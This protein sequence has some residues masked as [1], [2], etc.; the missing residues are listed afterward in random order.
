M[1]ISKS[2]RWLSGLLAVLMLMTTMLSN[3]VFAA[4]NV[5]VDYRILHVDCGRK[6]FSAES[7]KQAIDIAAEAGY[8]DVELAIGNDG[9]RFLLNDMSVT[10][11]DKTYKSDEVKAAIQAGNQDYY[12]EPNGINELTQTEMDD[13]IQYAVKKNIGIIPLLNSPGHMDAILAAMVDLGIQNAAYNGS[14]RTVDV[15]NA[16]AVAF[17]QALVGK[18]ID[19]FAGEGCKEFN[20]GADEYANDIS[21]MG[22]THLQKTGKY[23]KFVEYVNK[24]CALVEHAGMT[25]MA[26]NDGIYYNSNTTDRFDENLMVCYWS[27]G[28]AGYEVASASFIANQGHKMINTHGDYYY[29]LQDGDK[30]QRPSNPE[31]FNNQVFMDRNGNGMIEDPAGAM[32]CI[33]SDNPRCNGWDGSAVISDAAESIREVG[34]AMQVNNPVEPETKP[35][36]V[37]SAPMTVGG[38]QTV[39]LGE[40]AEWKSSAANVVE[41]KA[42]DDGKSATLTAKSAGTATITATTENVIYTA[43]VTVEN[44]AVPGEKITL[45]VGSSET[46]TVNGHVGTEGTYQ[47][48]DGIAAYTISHK[49][50]SA[51]TTD[52]EQVTD[53]QNGTY[54]IGDGNNWLTIENNQLN[55]TN[56]S[57]KATRWTITES[58]DGYIIRSQADGKYL[59]TGTS[60][61][62]HYLKLDSSPKEWNWDNNGGFK[63]NH[64][65]IW[66]TTYYLRYS[67]SGWIVTDNNNEGTLGTAYTLPEEIPGGPYTEITFTGKQVG[68]TTVTIDDKVYNIQVVEEDLSK[69][70]PLSIEYWITNATTTDADGQESFKIQANAAYGEAG[71]DLSVLPQTTQK[72]NRDVYYWRSRLL[73]KEKYNS[74]TSGTEEQTGNAG[75]DETTSGVGFTKVRYYAGAWQVFTENSEWVTVEQNH[76]LVAYYL[77]HIKVTDEVES[78][79]ADWGKKGDGSK[80]D[81]DYLDPSMVC[82]VSVQVVYEDNTTNPSGTDANSLASKTMCYGY[83]ETHRGIGTI[84]LQETSNYEIYKV[85]AETGE[86]RGSG[87]TWGPYQ[88][89]SFNWDKNPETVWEGTSNGQVILHNDANK[90]SSAGSNKNLMWDENYEAILLKV[91]VRAKKT[92]DSLT[93]HYMDK[94]AG[95]KEF[96]NYNI[97]VSG[98][99]TFDEGFALK[100]G[101]LVNNSVTN[102]YGQ[103]QTVSTDLKTLPQLSA[104][105]LYSNFT[106]VDAKRS[107]NGKE[108]WL[109][110]TFNNTKEYVID[111][112]L[113]V[114]ID[115]KDIVEVTEA[116]QFEVV[117][118]SQYGTAQVVGDKLQYTPNQALAGVDTVM[119]KVSNNTGEPATWNIYIYPASNVLYEDSFFAQDV[120]NKYTAWTEGTPDSAVQS[121]DNTTYGWDSAYATS[122]RENSMNSAWSVDLTQGQTTC[123]LTTTFT[124][125][126][127]DLIGTCGP[128]TGYVYLTLKNNTTG[129]GKVVVVD[130]SFN[131]TEYGTLHQVPLAHVELDEGTYTAT[132]FGSYRAAAAA[133]AAYSLAP[134]ANDTQEMLERAYALA[135]EV[136]SVEMIYFDDNSML[137]G[138]NG[139]SKAAYALSMDDAQP[140]SRAAGQP[141]GKIEIDGFRVYRPSDVDAYIGTEKNV[142]YTNILDAVSGEFG[143]YIEANANGEYTAKDYESK[144]GPQNEI[145]LAENQSIA[146]KFSELQA[147]NFSVRAVNKDSVSYTVQIG[148]DGKK[149]LFTASRTEMYQLVENAGDDAVV[150]IKNTTEGALLA[151]G[152]LKTG[153]MATLATMDEAALQTAYAMLSAPAQPEPE[154]FV[155]EKLDLKVSA[156]N[157]LFTKL[158]TLTVTASSDVDYLT[159]NGKKVQPVNKL[160]VQWGLSKNYTFVV[161][162]LVRRGQTQTYTVQA[163]SQDGVASAVQTV[164]G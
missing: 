91:Y 64:R 116:A 82:T 35:L 54:L 90:P 43:D 111:F 75:D 56:D 159:V 37:D 42:S 28:W 84:M 141:G 140:A 139:A 81:G 46:I 23:G 44:A 72:E 99:T 26:F 118:S 76:Q 19:Y 30:V 45:T 110:Y 67:W 152:N 100:D 9:L 71:I 12:N 51:G 70:E 65:V 20:I 93:V 4:S 149:Q 136:E 39:Q 55:N 77:E 143:A 125:N 1:R 36:P 50:Q 124:G 113:P 38:T 47:T 18:Y 155:P 137:A 87:D 14:K 127:F 79:A 150:T 52:P 122:N 109:Y 144:G 88:V 164:Q 106:C 133:A 25:P 85:T 157:G 92:E 115:L 69:V 74:S 160:L 57:A 135:G 158:T 63:Y 95:D 34:K 103:T 17:T 131:D 97:A 40:A 146:L 15:T 66:N 126:G 94:T 89:Y 145:Y 161:T 132:V 107:E 29:V 59:S 163:Y 68:Q 16:E 130:T 21:G 80:G 128:N 120:N 104:E 31:N 114:Q 102:Y 112:G 27:C 73:D 123:N 129:K 49:V 162:D 121:A 2:R 83:W 60:W 32:F 156:I 53:L 11:G 105:Y 6:Y 148:K 154:E 22:F 33:W 134:A 13:I 3:V 61:G 101:Q 153:A 8:T 147:L 117:G 96:Y 86:M 10:V 138:Q 78:F 58:G 7:L 48:P 62:S 24:L 151:L 142:T 108:V 5:D 119:L 41:V 98:G